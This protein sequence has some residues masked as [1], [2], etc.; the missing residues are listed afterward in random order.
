MTNRQWDPHGSRGSQVQKERPGTRGTTAASSHTQQRGSAAADST[1]TRR[2]TSLVASTSMRQRP[3]TSAPCTYQPRRTSHAA[4]SY[5]WRRMPLAVASTCTSQHACAAA[6]SSST[7]WRTSTTAPS[8]RQLRC[9][10]P[11]AATCTRRRASTVATSTNKTVA[12]GLLPPP[13][14]P[15]ATSGTPLSSPGAFTASTHRLSAGSSASGTRDGGLMGGVQAFP[16]AFSAPLIAAADADAARPRRPVSPTH[17]RVLKRAVPL[18]Q[19]LRHT[20]ARNTN[21]RH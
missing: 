21:H 11:T 19:S 4:S 10:S 18:S 16:S 15:P 17:S 5:Q 7:R 20:D 13:S 6:L 2:C 8:Y 9:T 1:S 3:A 14:K 12:R